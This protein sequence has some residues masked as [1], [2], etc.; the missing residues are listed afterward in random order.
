M[1]SRRRFWNHLALLLAVALLARLAGA[2]W[3][4]QRS[5]EGF[6]FP[7]SWSYW[8]LAETIAKGK[9]Y[10]LDVD[11]QV[12]RTPGY[13]ALLAPMF[14]TIAAE[15]RIFAARLLGVSLGVGTVAAIVGM[16]L[17]LFDEPTAL[18]AGWMAALYPGAIGMSVFILSEAPFCLVMIVHLWLWL[19]AAQSTSWKTATALA[20]AGGVAAGVATLIRP[21]WLLF[22][23]FAALICV[24]CVRQRLRHAGLCAAMMIGLCCTM[25]PW[26]VRN[27]LV[28]DQFTPTTLQMG[29]SLYDGL[30]LRATGASD[31]RFVLDFRAAQM[32]ADVAAHRTHDG[33]EARLDQRLKD[34]AIAW[35]I[36]HPLQVIGLAATKFVRMW[37]VWPNIDEFRSW[38][39]RMMVMLGYTPLMLAAGCGLTRFAKRGWVVALCYLPA[40]YFTL[41]HMIFV[42]SLRYRQPPM[43]ALIILAAAG[44]IH[45]VWPK[46]FRPKTPLPTEQLS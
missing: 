3:W 22:T 40:V 32:A 1:S 7:D 18:V 37:N 33:F 20:L 6:G 16:S 44:V 45:V 30:N 27:Y 46:L 39:M 24:A 35:A 9:P 29:A 41:L 8:Q 28:T 5:G 21:S 2:W 36:K 4:Q 14:W 38:P 34:A 10:Q 11:Q 31:M 19:T 15:H 12:F 23:P 42:S 25:A 43:L 26:W 13:P 17:R